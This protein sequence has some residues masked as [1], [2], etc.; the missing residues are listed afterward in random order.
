MCLSVTRFTGEEAGR[1][2]REGFDGLL[3]QSSAVRQEQHALG[4]V[5]AHQHIRQRNDGSGFAGACRHHD[6]RLALVVILKSFGDAADGALLIIAPSDF[7]VRLR[8]GQ[9]AAGQAALG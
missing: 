7:F 9:V 5:G 1:V 6:K 4:P 2:F 8:F 3:H